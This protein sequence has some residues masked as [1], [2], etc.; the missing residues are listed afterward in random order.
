[1]S[2]PTQFKGVN[3]FGTPLVSDNLTAGLVEWS[4]WSFLGIGAFTNVQ[5]NASGTYGGSLNKLR[6]SNTPNYARGRVWEGFRQEWIWESGIQYA[7][8]PIQISGVIVDNTFYP[9]STSGTYAHKISY[10]NG[11][12]IFNSAISPSADVRLNYSYRHVNVYSADAP[13]FKSLMLNSFRADNPQFLQ[14]GSGAW[15]ILAQNRV[16]LP[17][18]FIH[19]VP[20]FNYIGMQ[21]GGGQYLFQDALIM[22]LAETPFERNQISDIYKY[23]NE[24]TIALID[25]NIMALQ[26]RFPLTSQGMLSSGATCYPSWIR[27][28]GEGG[29]FY[30]NCRIASAAGD[31]F[32]TD[33]TNLYGAVVR[34]TCEIPL[35]EI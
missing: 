19:A 21:L 10:P 17:A 13:W 8:Q 18:V 33:M 14:E 30:R 34:Y 1:M 27:G 3:D 2:S 22:V 25:R 24:K 20:R 29:F 12:V 15:S 6:L 23:Q 4:K 26:N 35:W 5:P 28:S 7:H 31:I 32:E 9:S 11:Q 16:Q